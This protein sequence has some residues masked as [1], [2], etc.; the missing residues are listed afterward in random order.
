[1]K[2]NKNPWLFTLTLAY[3]IGY[4]TALPAVGLGLL[5]RFLD[6][7]FETSPL[8]LLISMALAMLITFLWLY[9]EIKKII[10]QVS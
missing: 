4:T 10:H 3:T 8:I 5:G 6:K 7:K 9:K 2:K 1:M